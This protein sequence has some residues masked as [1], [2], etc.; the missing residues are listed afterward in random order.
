MQH[1]LSA[2][3]LLAALDEWRLIDAE[4]NASVE[5]DVAMWPVALVEKAAD[6]V[7]SAAAGGWPSG[8]EGWRWWYWSAMETEDGGRSGAAVSVAVVL[9]RWSMP[10][11]CG[12][13]G[14]VNGEEQTM[15]S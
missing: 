13:E 6:A 12:R 8:E 10:Q 15:G 9:L 14:A 3:H 7:E 4:L 11:Q 5:L 2:P 1:A